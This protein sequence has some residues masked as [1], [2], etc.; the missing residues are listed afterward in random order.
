M[1]LEDFTED[2]I[3]AKPY[4]EVLSPDMR[5]LFTG[6]LLYYAGIFYQTRKAYTY[7]KRWDAGEDV[8]TI[9]GE[10]A[11]SRVSKRALRPLKKRI[12]K[13]HLLVSQAPKKDR[14][15]KN[16]LGGRSWI[17]KPGMYNMVIVFHDANR[18]GPHIDVHIGRFSIVYR[19][20]PDTYAKL[21]YNK[22]GELT[23]DS[24]ELL[25]NHVRSEAAN[26]SRVP[27]NLDHTVSG[28]KTTWLRGDT[29]SKAYGSGRTRQIISES[30]VNVYKTHADGPIEMYAPVINPNS[31]MYIYR[32][33]EGNDKRVPILIVGNKNDS[34]GVKLQDRLH[35][36]LVDP[37]NMAKAKVDPNT[38]TAKYD[39]SSCYVVIT[40]K[41]TTIWS[42]RTSVRSGKQIAYTHK[43]TNFADITSEQTVVGMGEI[44]F[45]LDGEYLPSSVGSGI[46]NS[47]GH[48]PEGVTPEIRLYRIDRVGRVNTNKLPFW[49][50]R[51]LQLAVSD[52]APDRLKVVEL[53]SPEKALELGFEGVVGVGENLSVNDGIKV[54]WW[55]DAK[56]WRIDRVEFTDGPKGGIAG[57]IHAT[58]L[59]SGKHFK[60]GPGQFADSHEI[61]KHAMEHPELY[62]GT[63]IKVL[64]RKGHDGRA[65]KVIW[66]HDDKGT[67][68][69]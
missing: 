32:I 49:E 40:P 30:K 67:A 57:V 42:P 37:K 45:E 64:S 50:N 43:L 10:Y 28:A 17:T 56:D 25:L 55:E 68:P 36:K 51:E 66:E 62:E 18:A 6:K 61:V 9:L 60:L 19:V 15:R 27:Q 24:K 14:Y 54:K 65:S 11:G 34:P 8:A 48:V 35:L 2:L 44:M 3:E 31:A 5:S 12:I 29:E 69:R 59:E 38:Y 33:Y 46:L 63:V 53:M 41:G 7:L 13:A 4:F 39:G 1:F 21:K 22:K 58:S 26:N 20:K 47:N 23:Q 52:L 16:G